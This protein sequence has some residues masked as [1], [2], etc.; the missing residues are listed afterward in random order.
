MVSQ[1]KKSGNHP[2]ELSI[3][4]QDYETDILPRY[5]EALSV[6]LISCK[7]YLQSANRGKSV[8]SFFSVSFSYLLQTYFSNHFPFLKKM[9]ALLVLNLFI[10]AT[11]SNY[12]LICHVRSCF[13]SLSFQLVGSVYCL[14]NF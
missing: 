1:G 3:P 10:G 9:E 14:I 4:A 2:V 8:G 12:V 13:V 6:G 11:L 5:K 7:N